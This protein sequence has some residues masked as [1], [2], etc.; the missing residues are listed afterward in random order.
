MMQRA[1]IQY[2]Q[3]PRR[4][5]AGLVLPIESKTFPKPELPAKLAGARK[6]LQETVLLVFFHFFLFFF[7]LK[8]FIYV[9]EYRVA[10]F[11]HTR[12]GHRIP[13]QMAVNH[14]VVAGI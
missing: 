10:V 14:H 9:Y 4:V 7:F 13:L 12:G 1:H 6:Q 8:R 5:L 11:R 3:V 2:H